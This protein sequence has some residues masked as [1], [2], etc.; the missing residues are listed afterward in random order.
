MP[1]FTSVQGSVPF[2]TSVT[3][4]VQ[5]RFQDLYLCHGNGMD[6]VCVT[7]VKSGDQD[8]LSLYPFPVSYIP[9]YITILMIV[10]VCVWGGGG[11]ER[12]ELAYTPRHGFREKGICCHHNSIIRMPFMK[13][14]F[15]IMNFVIF[16]YTTYSKIIII[17]TI[18]SIHQI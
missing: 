13:H 4:I 18:T 8:Y 2:F 12:G 5:S 7:F 9:I 3:D 15:C 14:T 11:G 10:C 17:T 6:Y 16:C 1:F